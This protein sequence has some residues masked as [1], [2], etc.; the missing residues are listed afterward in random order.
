MKKTVVPQTQFEDPLLRLAEIWD[1]P[2]LPGLLKVRYSVG[3]RK[4]LGRCRPATGEIR[5][6]TELMESGSAELLEEVLCHEAAHVLVYSRHGRNAKPHGPEWRK[7]VGDAGFLPR[8][9]LRV[10]S[11]NSGT[12]PTPAPPRKRSIFEHRCPVCQALWYAKKP[13]QAWR[14]SGCLE[15][16]LSGELQ[17]TEHPEQ[18]G[19]SI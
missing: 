17:I 11:G 14:C 5:L 7:L 2:Q 19:G 10:V 16:G 4:S 6:N 1:S 12:D 15:Q 18:N 8:V 3:L 13:M 9:S